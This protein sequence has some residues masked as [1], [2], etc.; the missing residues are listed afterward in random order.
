MFE[1]FIVCF[2]VYVPYM[3]D[4]M[5]PLQRYEFLT[6]ETGISAKFD[7]KKIVVPPW[8]VRQSHSGSNSPMTSQNVNVKQ[9]RKVASSACFISFLHIFRQ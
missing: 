5:L 2:F 4:C 3:V 8:R 9:S 7:I 6:L 1:T